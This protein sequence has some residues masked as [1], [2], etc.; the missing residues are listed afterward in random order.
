M[1]SKKN[2]AWLAAL[3]ILSFLAGC[4][5]GEAQPTPDVNLIFTQAAET[6]AAQ[7]SQTAAA[8]PTNTP[9]PTATNT[10]TSLSTLP[11]LTGLPL[12]GSA[13]AGTALPTLAL[14]TATKPVFS[15]P[16]KCLWQRNEPADGSVIDP[17][18]Q[19]DITWYVQNTGTTTWTKNYK[20]RYYVGDLFVDR[21][22]V[23]LP[24]EVQPNQ[25]GRAVM[26]ATAPSK[27]GT[28]KATF[29]LTNDQGVNFCV[30][31]FTFTVGSSAQATSGATATPNTLAWM[32]SDAERSKI[33]GEGCETYCGTFCANNPGSS[34]YVNGTDVCEE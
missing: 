15:G 14:A 19:F 20:V 22:E 23:N 18:K 8:K 24:E 26:D 30:I 31:D 9:Q 2:A 6:V 11:I 32:C 5:G 34:C 13:G 4:S 28:Y 17:K 27:A 1:Y 12:P 21:R 29:V 3:L 7:L 10:P 16:D 33:Q 25:V